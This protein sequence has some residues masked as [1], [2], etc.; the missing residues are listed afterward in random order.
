MLALLVLEQVARLAVVPRQ[1]PT[2]A[3]GGRARARHR[4]R[5][6]AVHAEH[7]GDLVAVQHVIG[8]L[9]VADAAREIALAAGRIH[10]DRSLVVF[11]PHGA[12]RRICERRLARALI[13]RSRRP[14]RLVRCVTAAAAAAAVHRPA[15]LAPSPHR[16]R[17]LALALLLLAQLGC[18][19][20]AA[21]QLLHHVRALLRRQSRVPRGPA[22][23]RLKFLLCQ[24]PL[25]RTAP[26]Q[27][28]RGA[29]A[30]V[31]GL[32]NQAIPIFRLAVAQAWHLAH[33]Q[34]ALPVAHRAAAGSSGWCCVTTVALA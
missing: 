13:Q 2:P 4:L 25:D 14:R 5:G 33:V 24:R 31:E 28:A 12:R 26:H 9:V 23:R 22:N 19:P 30:P 1:P 21:R 8:H 34:Q 3:L 20:P 16:L 27:R 11:A 10:L 29:L 32:G 15:G 18:L 17:Q 6:E 7:V